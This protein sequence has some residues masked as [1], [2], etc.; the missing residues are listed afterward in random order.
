MQPN[1]SFSPDSQRL[2]LALDDSTARLWD[3][4]SGKPI[5]EPIV[6][7]AAV[8]AAG[9]CLGGKRVYT[10]S[11]DGSVRLSDGASGKPIGN[12]LSHP[13]AVH[14]AVAS[15]RGDLLLTW[16]VD[17]Q[18]RLWN[19]D[20][21]AL[22]GQPMNHRGSIQQGAFSPDGSIL[23]TACEDQNAQLWDAA[24]GESIGIPLAHPAAVLGVGFGA[25]G[26]LLYTRAADDTVRLWDAN[27]QRP[28]PAV[29]RHAGLLAADMAP[30][31]RLLA[32]AGKDRTA[33]LWEATSGAAQ[34]E[35]LV[36]DGSVLDLRFAADGKLL[37]T[38]SS[39]GS[40]RLWQAAD[41]RPAAETLRHTRAVLVA[42][43]DALG[44]TVLT[45]AADGAVRLWATATSKLQG[46]PIRVAKD[47]ADTDPATGG[48]G[49]GVAG[50]TTK[51][52]NATLVRLG[53]DRVVT[54]GGVTGLFT[55]ITSGSDK[56][57]GADE[58]QNLLA[59]V[60]QLK[61][62]VSELQS[63]NLQL[64]ADLTTLRQRPTAPEDFASGVQQSLDE[65]QQRM[66]NMRNGTSNFAV[67]E[68]KLDASVFVQV[69]PLG[70]VEYRFVQPGDNA[71]PQAF[72]KIS[73]Q[74]VPLPKDN[75][76]G[77][78]AGSLFQPD[79]PLQALPDISPAQVAQLET[80]GLYSIGEYLSV[81]TRARAQAHLQAL[82]G[83]QRQR[84][85]LWAQ[86]ALLMTLRGVSGPAALLLIE[87]GVSAF[88]V[89]AALGPEALVVAYEAR[90]VQRPDLSAPALD[91]P[92]ARQWVRAARQYLGLAE[93]D[94]DAPKS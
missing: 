72:S 83:V 51:L 47:P 63:R 18:A 3:A 68:F 23:A 65:L 13:K 7:R 39:D 57:L 37:V 87:A 82:L 31:G 17:Q 11:E 19:T 92:Q 77:V 46:R 64:Q 48:S 25:G 76:A 54:V 38:A 8:T 49:G 74:V 34:G 36:H 50:T 2:V 89:L 16:C 41:G 32:T 30:G 21:G 61:R 24:T 84:L 59:I 1:D 15:P 53:G 81:A 71:P 60:D 78:W 28:L 4:D 94:E 55:P 33:R 73:M 44:G 85:A 66:G 91:L 9:F 6:H 69:T 22:I 45:L 43:F 27:T 75:L 79:T 5:G 20:T 26:K 14:G 62:E 93:T 58:R 80:A 12:P 56:P 29:I 67:R 90:R 52:D 42:G 40:A 86:Q 70:S 10:A 88:E 35:P